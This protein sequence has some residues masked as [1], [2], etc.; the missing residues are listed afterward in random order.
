MFEQ[1]NNDDDDDWLDT[2]D[3]KKC[4][5]QNGQEVMIAHAPKL[6]FLYIQVQKPHLSCKTFVSF[7]RQNFHDLLSD[8][9]SDCNCEEADGN[10][11][12]KFL[13]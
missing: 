4:N 6:Q 9:N 11:E 2:E 12:K 3:S 7:P 1:D 5:N 8:R 10:R 13:N